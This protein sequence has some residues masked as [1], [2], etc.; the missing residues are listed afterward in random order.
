MRYHSSA[1]QNHSVNH[2]PL[3]AVRGHPMQGLRA[4][5]AV[6][7]TL[8]ASLTTA[9]VAGALAATLTVTPPEPPQPVLPQMQPMPPLPKQAYNPQLHDG[10][11]ALNEADTFTAIDPFITG[12]VPQ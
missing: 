8:A 5:Y 4:K 2:T 1:V 6:I 12:P 9:W 7:T 10:T 3:Q 11:I